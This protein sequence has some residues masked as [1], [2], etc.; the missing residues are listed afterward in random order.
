MIVYGDGDGK[1]AEVVFEPGEMTVIP[2]ALPKSY[3]GL[4]MKYSEDTGMDPNAILVILVTMG[5]T[6]WKEGMTKE[7]AEAVIRRNQELMKE[8]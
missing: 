2:V 7:D 3:L 1:G 4:L 6:A 5:I 8:G